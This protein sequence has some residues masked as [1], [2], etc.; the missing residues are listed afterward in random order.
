MF[1]TKRAAFD[2]AEQRK[3]TDATGKGAEEIGGGGISNYKPKMPGNRKGLAARSSVGGSTAA[4]GSA[5]KPPG[6]IPKWKL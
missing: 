1:Q 4:S 6:K 5:Q 3:A 2:V